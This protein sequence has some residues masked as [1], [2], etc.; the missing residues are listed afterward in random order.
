[1]TTA[2][3]PDL[4][5]TRASGHRVAEHVLAAGQFAAAGTIRLRAAPGGF[6]TVVGVDGRQLA[7]DGS[8]LVVLD[9]SGRRA[10]PLTTLGELAEF[11]GVEPGL[12]G[13]YSP[14][15]PA[16]LDAPLPVDA[17]AARLLAGW[18]ALG[19]TALR[20]FA[21]RLDRPADPVLWP[22]HFDLGITVDAVNY[23]C[24]PGD[25]A[26][27]EPYVYVGPHAGPP[28]RNAFWNAPFGAALTAD[29][30]TD[31]DDAVAF[32]ERGRALAIGAG[33]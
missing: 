6:A 3:S 22:E 15:T 13:S 30:I 18:F 16:D 24:S 28:G 33:E 17:A 9:G 26:I 14:S 7:V 23:G 2:A 10:T 19:D 4:I 11:A 29:G 20:R 21:D 1:M 31:A 27:P 25:D 12:R 5:A 8:D 32:F